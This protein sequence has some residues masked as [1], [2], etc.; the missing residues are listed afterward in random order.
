MQQDNPVEFN[1]IVFKKK[2]LT[3]TEVY[4]YQRVRQAE[5]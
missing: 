2:L 4:V 5:M 3:L 1:I